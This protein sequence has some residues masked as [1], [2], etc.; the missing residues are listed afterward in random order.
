MCAHRVVV[1]VVLM[2]QCETAMSIVMHIKFT[3]LTGSIVSQLWKKQQGWQI[4]KKRKEQNNQNKSFY[5]RW[6]R[7]IGAKVLTCYLLKCI[8]IVWLDTNG[9]EERV[10]GAE[11]SEERMC[12]W[13]PNVEWKCS[14]RSPTEFKLGFGIFLKKIVPQ[15][16]FYV[17][18]QLWYKKK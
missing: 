8:S 2:V 17:S 1:V 16:R 7:S 13:A 15:E 18:R 4:K 3:L 5:V 11:G 10:G 6:I 14:S 12:M 9:W